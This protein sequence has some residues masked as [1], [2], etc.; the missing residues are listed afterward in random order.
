MQKLTPCL[1]FDTQ[2]EEAVNFYVSIFKNSRINA[3]T[4]YGDAA[5]KGAHM[6]KGSVLTIEFDLDGQEFLALNGGPVFSFTPAISYI[7]NC[8]TQEE[9]DRM[10][11]KLTEGGEEVQCG[12]LKDKYGMSWQIV[13]RIM[14]EFMKDKDTAKTERV[15]AAMMGMVKLNIKQLQAAFDGH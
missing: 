8:D 7:V 14:F 15:M 3:I 1:W 5:S 12:W 2:A 10:W 13:P 6:P 4:R 11:A 9:L